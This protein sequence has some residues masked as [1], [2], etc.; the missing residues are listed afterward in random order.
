[1]PV[2]RGLNIRSIRS[3]IM[4]PPT[5]LIEEAVTARTPRIVESPVFASPATTREP[6]NAMPEIA[7]VSA[8][9]GV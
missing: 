8:M 9:S 4:K 6:T 3:V 1:M 5:T 7:F 2:S